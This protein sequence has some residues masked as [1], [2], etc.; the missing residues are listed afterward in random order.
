MEMF[1][2]VTISAPV[3]YYK[4]FFS[5]ISVQFSTYVYTQHAYYSYMK[6]QDILQRAGGKV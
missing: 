3:I 5:P 2:T 1:R 4:G 6:I